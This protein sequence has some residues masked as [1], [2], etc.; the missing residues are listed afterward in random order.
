MPV[1]IHGV[2]DAASG[3][4]AATINKGSSG[5]PCIGVIGQDY[6]TLPNTAGIVMDNVTLTVCKLAQQQLQQL[7]QLVCLLVV[8]TAQLA[9]STL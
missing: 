4:A 6:I 8:S 7:Q 5:S 9:E 1:A 3:A 2:V